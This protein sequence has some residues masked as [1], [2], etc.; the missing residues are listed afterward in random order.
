MSP[1]EFLCNAMKRIRDIYS[2]P[3]ACWLIDRGFLFLLTDPAPIQEAFAALLLNRKGECPFPLLS[4]PR[5]GLNSFS[6]LTA[7]QASLSSVGS[8]NP[9]HCLLLLL[10]FSFIFLVLRI[11]FRASDLLN[12]FSATELLSQLCNPVGI[13]TKNLI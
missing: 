11:E 13:L 3:L 1:K 10:L 8:H 7:V 9:A 12:L 4:R 2:L 6:L 5:S